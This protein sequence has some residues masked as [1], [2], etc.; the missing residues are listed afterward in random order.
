MQTDHEHNTYVSSKIVI[1]N[2]KTNAVR[3]ELWNVDASVQR[4]GLAAIFYNAA[5]FYHLP[6]GLP[7][8]SIKLSG[9]SVTVAI[10][11]LELSYRPTPSTG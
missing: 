3:R 7:N 10:C 8:S 5:Y 9:S 2:L 1:R 11:V 4:V 6:A